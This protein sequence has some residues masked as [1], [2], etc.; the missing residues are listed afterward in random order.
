MQLEDIDRLDDAMRITTRP[1]AHFSRHPRRNGAPMHPDTNIGPARPTTRMRLLQ[2]RESSR[3]FWA[4]ASRLGPRCIRTSLRGW[5]A[6]AR[7]VAGCACWDAVVYHAALLGARSRR[8]MLT[9]CARLTAAGPQQ[10]GLASDGA[11]ALHRRLT[12]TMALRPDL[13]VNSPLHRA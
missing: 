12:M 1:A 7:Q 5:R 2:S 8:S 3:G 13:V 11:G 9:N 6:Y 4:V 10:F